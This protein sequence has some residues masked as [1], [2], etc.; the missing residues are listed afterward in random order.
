MRIPPPALLLGTLLLADP[1]VVAAQSALTRE[2][3]LPRVY[4]REIAALWAVVGKRHDFSGVDNI[5][6]ASMSFQ[7]PG[8]DKGIVISNGRTESFIKYKEVVY[9]LWHAGYSVYVFDHRGQGFSGRILQP[10]SEGSSSEAKRALREIG[11]VERFDDYVDD[12]KTFVDRVVKPDSNR[13][14]A[15][16]THS[17]G[18]AIA[19]LYLQKHS[20]DFAAAVLMSPMH[21]PNI[22]PLP[23]RQCWM[24]KIRP[25]P[26]EAPVLG[27]G[28]FV[29][30]DDFSP[31][32]DMTS[33]RI[34]F[35]MLVRSEFRR[36]PEARLGGPSRKWAY[37]AC[38]A[39]TRAREEAGYIT[40]PVLVLQAGED[41]VVEPKGQE[42]FCK[43]MNEVSL[44][45]CSIIKI[46][47]ARHEMLIERD[48]Y[49]DKVLSFALQFIA[50]H[51]Q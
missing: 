49:R 39:A 1:C 15:L 51:T 7:N 40:A 42:Q 24:F 22:S 10:A 3:D 8:S 50:A 18:G 4:E 43:K 20:G 45:S 30:T 14:L 41:N 48:E 9:D 6:I 12:L 37:E 19:S 5:Q 27:K 16:L 29:D 11:H 38:E 35:E 33:S 26:L 47:G 13:N 21:E 34:R 23:R 46:R 31:D 28:P 32:R 2:V 36:H 25:V 44:N 17:M